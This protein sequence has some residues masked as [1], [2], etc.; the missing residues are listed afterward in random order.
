MKAKAVVVML[1]AMAGLFAPG[2][3]GSVVSPPAKPSAMPAQP[4]RSYRDFE[5]RPTV[6]SEQE[7]ER[8][9]SRV[10]SRCSVP[11]GTDPAKAPWYF[12]YEMGLE[13]A[14]HGDPQRALDAFL[15][16]VELRAEPHRQARMYGMWFTNYLP[17]LEIAKAHAALGNWQC[18]ADA[19]RISEGREV[20]E[21]EREFL[22]L[23]EIKSEIGARTK[24]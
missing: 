18:A 14:R 16:A 6:L 21:G 3:R 24:N 7:F 9:R 12:H 22:D 10:L 4:S 17:Y 11:P 5:R 8:L 1:V 23:L 13:L 20:A 15:E 19:V 2:A